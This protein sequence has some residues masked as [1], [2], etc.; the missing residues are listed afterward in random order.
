MNLITEDSLVQPTHILSNEKGQSAIEFIMTF[1]FA[2]GLT[3][4]FIGHTMN[5]TSG[6]LA[7]YVNFMSSRTYLTVEAGSDSFEANHATATAAAKEVF[8]RFPLA[9]FGVTGKHEIQ[10]YETGGAIFAGSTFYFEQVVS[11]MPV[12]GGNQKAQF[13]TESLL[14]KEPTITNCLEMVCQAITGSRGECK[15]ATNR[16]ITLYDNGC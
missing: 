4:L 13:L 6:Y 5:V 10:S 2:A 7:H 15:N 16:S 1:I 12:I 9:Q 3:F 11:L 14:G 8:D